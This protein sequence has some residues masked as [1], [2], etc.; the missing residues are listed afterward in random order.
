[1]DAPAA[2]QR[3][4]HDQ[5]KLAML[6]LQGERIPAG[7]GKSPVRQVFSKPETGFPQLSEKR[8]STFRSILSCLPRLT[9][10][11]AS[12]STGARDHLKGR[13]GTGE[14]PEGVDCRLDQT[15]GGTCGFT[16]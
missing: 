8:R 6:E 12:A 10:P 15:L 9:I 7:L 3:N 14:G 5:F 11:D 2:V 16:C 4:F 1:M 13:I